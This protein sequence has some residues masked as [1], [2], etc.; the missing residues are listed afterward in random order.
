MRRSD[1][2]RI[3]IQERQ[4]DERECGKR[5]R[6]VLDEPPRGG[7]RN[8]TEER[9]TKADADRP[10]GQHHAHGR[11][12]LS[13]GEPLRRHLRQN[14]RQEYAAGAAHEPACAGLP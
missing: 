6:Q 13:A 1:A 5:G 11:R 2:R 9:G 8:R 4:N 7:G 14:E 3:P 12:N 10:T